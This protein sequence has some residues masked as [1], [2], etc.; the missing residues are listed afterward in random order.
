MIE[1][2]HSVK[3]THDE[4]APN[5]R[6]PTHPHELS[7]NLALYREEDGSEWAQLR[8]G[9]LFEPMPPKHERRFDFNKFLENFRRSGLPIMPPVPGCSLSKPTAGL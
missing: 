3:R 9:Y 6:L 8:I 7:A 2:L 4:I 1:R 5:L